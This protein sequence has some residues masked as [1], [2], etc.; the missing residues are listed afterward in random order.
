MRTLHTLALLIALF[1]LVPV[2]PAHAQADCEPVEV[3]TADIAGVYE[4]F[5]AQMRLDLMPCGTVDVLWSNEDGTHQATYVTVERMERGGLIARLFYP[6]P[7]VHSLDG[8]N[9]VGIKP[10]EPDWVEAWTVGPFGDNLRVY[11]LQKIS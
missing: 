1:A 6:D 4:S 8:R 3:A 2:L 7:L 5:E 11:R 10:A 9:V